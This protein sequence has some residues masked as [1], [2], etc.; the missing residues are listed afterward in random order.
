MNELRLALKNFVGDSCTRARKNL[1]FA[2]RVALNAGE[3]FLLG[4][5][6]EAFERFDRLTM[7]AMPMS[8]ESKFIEQVAEKALEDHVK[9]H[10]V[11]GPLRDWL[12]AAI[13]SLRA[14]G[15]SWS[16]IFSKLGQVVL[17]IVGGGG[18]WVAVITAILALF[19]K[20]PTPSDLNV[21]A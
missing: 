3:S 20:T 7:G 4:A 1:H 21:P 19:S 9:V 13:T 14:S 18:N 17:I 16:D 2:E 10:G 8:D 15:I 5:I 12:K 11:Q 6:D